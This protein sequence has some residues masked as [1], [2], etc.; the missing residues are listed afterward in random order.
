MVVSHDVQHRILGVGCTHH[1]GRDSVLFGWHSLL[2]I[3]SGWD[4]TKTPPLLTGLRADAEP[5]E[6]FRFVT[7]TQ[8]D[9]VFDG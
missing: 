5:G 7:H 8:K 2:T 3:S 4:M 1:S 6:E 9:E